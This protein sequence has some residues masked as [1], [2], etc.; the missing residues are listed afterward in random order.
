MQDQTLKFDSI[1]TK[2]DAL[3]IMHSLM[4]KFEITVDDI[5]PNYCKESAVATSS[6][7]FLSFFLILGGGILVV[8]LIFTIKKEGRDRMFL[9]VIVGT[10]MYLFGLT[11]SPA[12]GT[13][14]FV[15]ASIL[16]G[17]GIFVFIDNKVQTSSTFSFVFAAFVAEFLL[18][19]FIT[20][21]GGALFSAFG[22]GCITIF[23]MLRAVQTPAHEIVLLAGYIILLFTFLFDSVENIDVVPFFYFISSAGIIGGTF[24]VAPI[25]SEDQWMFPTVNVALLILSR[26]MTSKVVPFN[27]G[28]A[29][30]G[31]SWH[32]IRSNYKQSLGPEVTL[33]MV[34]ISI[35]FVGWLAFR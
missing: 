19:Y 18:A 30:V 28:V 4:R 10:V 32:V 14:V 25:K 7:G 33:L 11:C 2:D 26:W 21:S 9:S 17:V 8:A 3:L 16:Q 35:L 15:V 34:G 20:K 6:M 12:I 29:L 5:S 31:Y 24:Y 22:Y 27:A 23:N 13:V 1:H